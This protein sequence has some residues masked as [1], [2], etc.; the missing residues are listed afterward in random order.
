M[1][2]SLSLKIQSPKFKGQLNNDD[3]SEGANVYEIHIGSVDTDKSPVKA[4]VRTVIPHPEF[5]LNCTDVCY[6]IKN[7]IAVL[8]LSEPLR[9]TKRIRPIC[10][11]LKFKEEF[12]DDAYTAG[13]GVH[14]GKCMEL[15]AH[16]FIRTLRKAAQR[17]FGTSG[18]GRISTRRCRLVPSLRGLSRVSTL[19]IGFASP[20]IVQRSL[21][22]G[23]RA[24]GI[25][26]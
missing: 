1:L 21:L 2:M 11:P 22:T 12:G 3:F 19:G 26:D 17:H 25:G 18:S 10:L 13:W 24:G 8:E 15:D 6:E 9:F 5:T 16:K 14:D 23:D 4:S 20:G 7:D